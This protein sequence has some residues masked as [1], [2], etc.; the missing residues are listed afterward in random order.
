M[1]A[2]DSGKPEMPHIVLINLSDPKPV[3]VDIRIHSECMTGDVFSSSRCD[4][5]E[6]LHLSL[7]H[8]A[9]NGGALIYLRQE[10]RGIGL[11]NKLKAYNLQDA[12]MDTIVA[13]V[14]LGFHADERDYSDAVAILHDL[15]IAKVRV[16]TNNPDKLHALSEAGIEILARLPLEVQA[17]EENRNYLKTKKE[18]FGHL[19]GMEA[20][21]P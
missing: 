20:G 21:F 11:V 13:N 15:G 9:E 18:S 7:K 6:Q 12:G 17:S 10:G 3:A 2:F 14:A 19:F 1:I 4:C 16:L 5:G 8:L